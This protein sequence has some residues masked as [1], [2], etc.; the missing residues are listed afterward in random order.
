MPK[1]PCHISDGPQTPEDQAE[2]H[3]FREE[4]PDEAYELERQAALDAGECHR[5]GDILIDQ[6]C[7]TCE[8]DKLTMLSIA[9]ET[10]Q[11]HAASTLKERHVGLHTKVSKYT[12]TTLYSYDQALWWS[13]EETAWNM[14]KKIESQKAEERT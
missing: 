2:L 5:C 4:D 1:M 6:L 12:K 10:D 3:E 13:T 8:S 11:I 7:P 14:H 9:K